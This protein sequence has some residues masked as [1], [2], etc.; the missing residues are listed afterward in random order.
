MLPAKVAYS[1]DSYLE[2]ESKAVDAGTT[3]PASSF[4]IDGVQYKISDK[5]YREYQKLRAKLYKEYADKI[6]VTD[7]YKR[8]TNEQKKK[9]LK[10][11]QSKATE[12][13]RKQLNIK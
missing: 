10:K 6:I 8:M 7:A 4:T 1:K 12:E 2:Q 13:A 5:K 9:Q 3:G 11:L